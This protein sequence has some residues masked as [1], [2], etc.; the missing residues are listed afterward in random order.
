MLR[1]VVITDDYLPAAYIKTELK[2]LTNILH[3]DISYM[4]WDIGGSE[5]LAEINR[6]VELK[7]PEAYT[8][9]REIIN[10]CQDAELVIT[11]FCPVN[12]TL[13]ES[14][15]H[16]KFICVMRGGVENLNTEHATI[17]NIL[18]FNI[19]GLVSDAVADFAVGLIL[20]ETRNIARSHLNMVAGW[21]VQDYS[22]SEHVYSLKGR[23]VGIIG[24]GEIGFKVASRLIPFGVQLLGYEPTD[25]Y[26][27][28]EDVQ[29]IRI[30]SLEDLLQKSDIVTVHARLMDDTYKLINSKNIKLMKSS[31]YLINTA[32]AGLVD[33]K[34]LIDALKAKRIA[35][36]AIDVYDNEPLPKNHVFRKLQNVT[37]TPHIA[38][39]T[40]DE[41][42]E[43]PNKLRIA[44]EKIFEG[45]RPGGITN[46]KDVNIDLVSF[47]N[48]R[49]DP[50]STFQL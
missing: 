50:S 18:Y 33:E 25:K 49:K 21:W 8:I 42:I 3:Y 27:P 44:L 13:I 6:L 17:K 31:A 24:L 40:I 11:H 37:L 41:R 23:V 12:K 1:I 15:P 22:N 16:L 4:A 47:F 35:G 9:P 20:A 43:T 32:R 14:C 30:V 28:G 39:K 5:S 45:D 34:A 29:G 7:G 19:P 2:K 46:F 38:G 48:T 10:Q 26:K 36:A